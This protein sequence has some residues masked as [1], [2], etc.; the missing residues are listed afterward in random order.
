MQWSR[1][2]LLTIAV[3]TA[4]APAACG[5]SSPAS[6]SQG[7]ERCPCFGNSTCNSG[8]TCASNTCVSLG[9]AGGATGMGGTTGSGG[10]GG[11][12]KGG[13]G[14]TDSAGT[15][16]PSTAGAG[17][18][19][20]A[21]TGGP[22]GSGGGGAGGGGGG[23]SCTNTSTDPQSC[24]TCGHVCKSADPTFGGCP[25]GGCCTAGKC[26]PYP[27]ACITQPDGFTTCADYCASVGETCVEKGCVRGSVTFESWSSAD[28][29]DS[30]FNPA[31]GF[32]T[33]ACDSTIQ[34]TS[35]TFRYIRCCCTDTH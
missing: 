29:C 10:T 23:G 30:F 20:A 26:G 24:G 1:A 34:W 3:A 13:A 33:G 21:G 14:G 32:S 7:T 5:G 6:C 22:A 25:M 19:S 11:S 27:G 28:L 9:G 31:P 8:L 17:G 18:T 2:W 12:S 4:L 15:G 16:G 35:G